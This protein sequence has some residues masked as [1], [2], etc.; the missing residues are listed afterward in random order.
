MPR[1]IRLS[2]PLILVLLLSPCL[3][4]AQVNALPPPFKA[5]YDVH[6]GGVKVGEMQR[7]L[8]R[9]G[10]D[11]YVFETVLYSTGMAAIL[12]RHRAVEASTWQVEDGRVLPQ[13]YT[14]TYNRADA[15]LDRDVFDWEHGVAQSTRKGRTVDLPL[16]AGVMDKQLYQFAL[17]RDLAHGVREATYQV[18]DRGRIRDYHLEVQ[19]E[20]TLATPLGDLRTVRLVKG[21]TTIWCAVDLNYMLV[22]LAK[23]EDGLPLTSYITKLER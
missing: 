21:P 23:E 16:A 2:V 14:L 7:E 22:K 9:Q 18:V 15:P 8:R 4:L 10:E 19:G 11:V 5:Y 17:T 13:S 3:C 6:A 12:K 20:E 1:P